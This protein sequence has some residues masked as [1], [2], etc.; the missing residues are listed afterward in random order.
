M[1]APLLAQDSGLTVE[2]SIGDPKTYKNTVE[3]TLDAEKCKVSL[4]GTITEEGRMRIVKVNEYWL[5]F[6]PNGKIILFQNHDRP[7]VIGKIGNILGEAK[8]NIANF[9]LGRKDNSGLALGA[10]EIDSDIDESIRKKLEKSGDMLWI[11][12]IDFTDAE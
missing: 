9:A 2:E 10:L 11:T 4:I 8:I 7:G 5:D 3:I 12:L 1:L 6:V